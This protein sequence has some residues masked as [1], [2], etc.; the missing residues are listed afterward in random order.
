MLRLHSVGL[1]FKWIRRFLV[2]TSLAFRQKR[3]WG[4]TAMCDILV[5]HLSYISQRFFPLSRCS[6]QLRSFSYR[7]SNLWFTATMCANLCAFL[8]DPPS[9]LRS[10]FITAIYH[11]LLPENFAKHSVLYSYKCIVLFSYELK[12]KLT[13]S[14]R[15][16]EQ[17][18][19]NNWCTVEQSLTRRWL[20]V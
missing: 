12:Y 8:A 7:R 10:H 20:P 18:L 16:I 19:S 11:T 13:V 5:K 15:I 2:C 4:C 17:T 3:S 6:H 14:D 9:I 1:M